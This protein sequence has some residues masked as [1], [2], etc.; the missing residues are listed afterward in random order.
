[1]PAPS[2]SLSP[3]VDPLSLSLLRGRALLNEGAAKPRVPLE[4]SCVPKSVDDYATRRYRTGEA[5]ALLQTSSG[6]R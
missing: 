2:Q 1:M 4:A 6:Q 5:A 3:V